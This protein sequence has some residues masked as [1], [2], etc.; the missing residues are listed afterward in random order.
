[1]TTTIAPDQSLLDAVVEQVWTLMLKRPL[2]PWTSDVVP[3]EAGVQADITVTG[4]FTGSLRL[5][6]AETAADSMTRTLLA[7][8]LVGDPDT[9]DV[10]DAVGELLNVIAGSLKGALGGTSALGLPVVTATAA[11]ELDPADLHLAV[12]WHDEP[13]LVS[14]RPAG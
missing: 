1:M 2:M 9:E 10:E 6:C 8:S 4:D 11:P 12:S 3:A 13:V 7:S 5:W 14:I